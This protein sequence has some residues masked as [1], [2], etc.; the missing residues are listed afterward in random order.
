M[1][2]GAG[3]AGAG[4]AVG[5]EKAIGDTIP[6]KRRSGWVNVSA[7]CMQPTDWIHL[8][9]ARPAGLNEPTAEGVFGSQQILELVRSLEA[10][11]TCIVLLSGGGSALL[12]APREGI[13]LQEK[14]AV[15][16]NAVESRSD[17]RGTQLCAA[18]SFFD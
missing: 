2:V 3:K 7:D 16:R 5:L 17:N 1:V 11:D 15:T 14:L 10:A 12:P 4:M 13:T 6:A 9:A 8:H 18:S